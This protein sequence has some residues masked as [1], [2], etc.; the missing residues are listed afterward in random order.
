MNQ[1][2]YNYDDDLKVNWKTITTISI[3]FKERYA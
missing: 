1:Y 3:Y 2:N